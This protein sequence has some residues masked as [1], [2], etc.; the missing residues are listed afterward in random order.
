MAAH[1]ITT[2]GEIN[3][4]LAKERR[5]CNFRIREVTHILDGGQVNTV[6]RKRLGKLEPKLKVTNYI[7]V[8]LSALLTICSVYF[9]ASIIFNYFNITER[10]RCSFL[11]NS[12]HYSCPNH[13]TY[14]PTVQT[15]TTQA[16][17]QSQHSS[18]LDSYRLPSLA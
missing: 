17:F 4:D 2:L 13:N 8:I 1:K 7:S 14:N 3:E 10:A 16:F 9:L 6:Q 15:N 5:N 11:N 18:T 12:G